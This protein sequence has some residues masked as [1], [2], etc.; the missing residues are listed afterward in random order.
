[1]ATLEV[2]RAPAAEPEAARATE[3]TRLLCAAAYTEETFAEE[4]LEELVEEEYRAVAVPPGVDPAPVIKHCLE[5][6]RQKALRNRVLAAMLVVAMLL[7]VGGFGLRLGYSLAWA[8]VAYYVARRWQKTLLGPLLTAYFLLSLL[9]LATAGGIAA[10]VAVSFLVAWAT[11]AYDLWRSTYGIAKRDLNRRTFDPA[12]AP[13]IA[14]SEL[15]RRMDEIVE[16]QDGNLTVYSGFLPFAGSGGDLGGWSFV[17][18]LRKG[19]EGPTGHRLTPKPVQALD[20]YAGVERSLRDLGMSNVTIEDRVF[21]NGTDIRDDR[22]LLPSPTGRPSSGIGDLELRRLMSTPTH[23]VRH[24]K[25]IRVIDWR[26]ELVLSLFLR[27]SVANERLFCELSGFLLTP[28][29]AEL[30]RIDGMPTSPELGDLLWLA[31]RSLLSTVPL[32]RRSP[33]AVLRPT[34][35]QRQ[36]AKLL[37]RVERDPFFDYGAGFNVLD[38]ARSRE[39]SRYFQLLD[40]EMHAKVLERSILDAI[41][42]VLDD[43]NIDTAELVER[44]S[45]IINHGIMVGEGSVNAEKMAVG[46]GAAIVE[47]F[48]RAKQGGSDASS[49]GSAGHG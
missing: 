7:V 23:R 13:E 33:W 30:H 11:V 10:A 12:G 31:R 38:R 2:G 14:S 18:D 36:R 9:F 20:L 15:V 3:T 35:R 21:V 4:V 19:N 16:H 25:C 39:Y 27:F 22:D 34:L 28:L 47:G 29:K 45:T 43:H 49:G 24:Y 8:I 44:R 40:K 41:V 5:A 1:M 46:T 48:K 26:G 42:D 17:I 6:L 32:W 37:R